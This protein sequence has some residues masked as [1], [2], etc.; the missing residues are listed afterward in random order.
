M[1]LQK[2]PSS[3]T[4]QQEEGTQQPSQPFA[5]HYVRLLSRLGAFTL[6]NVPLL[7]HVERK[8]GVNGEMALVR[9]ET[10]PTPLEGETPVER[11]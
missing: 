7:P 4:D 2:H 5:K 1:A 11:G 10:K 3:E 9:A 6:L 8:G